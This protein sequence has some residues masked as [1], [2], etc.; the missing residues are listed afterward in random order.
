MISLKPRS[1]MVLTLSHLDVM[2]Y[3]IIVCI[4]WTSVHVLVVLVLSNT[5]TE[6]T[7]IYFKVS[8]YE[9]PLSQFY[10]LEFYYLTI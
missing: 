7:T 9:L 5:I 4:F 3:R 10:N 8:Q 1:V 6:E 2:F